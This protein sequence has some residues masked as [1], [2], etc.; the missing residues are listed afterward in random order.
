MPFTNTTAAASGLLAM[1]AMDMYRVNTSLLTPPEAPGLTA[2]GWAV[3]AYI[4]GND[5]LL[6]GRL[7]NQVAGPF[8]TDI[9][10]SEG[11][12]GRWSR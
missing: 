9:W 12:S 2:A 3:L 1:H 4:I 11:G 6:R 8:A 5:T 7:S 10:R